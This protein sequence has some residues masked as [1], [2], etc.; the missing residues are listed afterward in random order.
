MTNSLLG[1]KKY[2]LSPTQKCI[3]LSKKLKATEYEKPHD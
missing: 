3:L 2:Y 1:D